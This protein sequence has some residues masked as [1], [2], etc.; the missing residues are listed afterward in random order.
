MTRL[1]AGRLAIT[2][3]AMLALSPMA[4]AS[5]QAEGAQKL[6]IPQTP[7]TPVRTP[8]VQGQCSQGLFIHYKLVEL[9]KEGPAG[10]TG[11]TGST[12]ATGLAGATG[13]AGPTGAR[14]STGP[15]GATG[16]GGATGPTGERGQSQSAQVLDKTLKAENGA[17]LVPEGVQLF[18]LDEATVS[19]ECGRV[20]LA[21]ANVA[22]LSMQG[23]AGTRGDAGL[24]E[25][26]SNDKPLE[27][28]PIIPLVRDVE[29]LP[30]EE[31]LI[32]LLS[33]VHEPDANKGYVD[34]TVTT[35]SG[36]IE[37]SAYVEASPTEPNCTVHGTAF[38]MST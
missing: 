34:A 7:N 1:T 36:A 5:A 20:P 11:A 14:G 33:G 22:I 25:T 28:E 21:G 32:V 12:G 30:E 2:S 19:F 35:P 38:G 27:A 29:V 31:T 10:P 4:T 13:A 16:A 3:L 6:C 17:S 9:G 24:I 26:K 18:K 8:N 37:I 23:P 15:T